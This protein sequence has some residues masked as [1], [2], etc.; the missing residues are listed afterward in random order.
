MRRLLKQVYET[1]AVVF[2]GQMRFLKDKNA[3]YVLTRYMDGAIVMIV[4]TAK[5]RARKLGP[6]HPGTL[7]SRRIMDEWMTAM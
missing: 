2:D 5:A 1:Q 6:N 3:T 4:K 7:Y